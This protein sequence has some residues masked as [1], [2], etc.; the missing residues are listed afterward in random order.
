MNYEINTTQEL[1]EAINDMINHDPD[2]LQDYTVDDIIQDAIT[3]GLVNPLL[4]NSY[5]G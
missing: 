1:N 4:A 3:H 2:I 5:N